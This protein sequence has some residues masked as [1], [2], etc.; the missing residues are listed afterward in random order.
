MRAVIIGTDFLKDIDG[1]FKAIETNTNIG[2][3]VAV[4]N[5][6]DTTS[7]TNFVL[8][9]SFT[10]IHLIYTA[11][12]VSITDTIEVEADRL[13]FLNFLK[14]SICEPNEITFVKHKL[15][16]NS[17]TIPFI[18]DG[19]N[20]LIIRIS[21]D[22]TAL[23]D[24]TYAR[25]NWEFL[26]LMYDNSPN[27]IPKCYINDTEFGI[28]NIG[29]TLRDN[30]NHPNYVIKKRITPTDNKIY[31]I[32]HKLDTIED[33][34]NLKSSLELDEYIQEYIL[35]SLCSLPSTSYKIKKYKIKIRCSACS[36]ESSK[37]PSDHKIINYIQK[38]KLSNKI[39]M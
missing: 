1:S 29:E 34:N 7:F 28:D 17:L 10:E 38:N 3:D 23:L 12:N 39:T 2:I 19:D 14:T 9:N 31:P 33:L 15:D 8:D 6:I 5:Y 11:V 18:E 36:N 32:L 16:E 26:K 30:G 22:T 37:L 35:C 4:N 27:S 24:D 21:Y 20:K 13:N 25:D